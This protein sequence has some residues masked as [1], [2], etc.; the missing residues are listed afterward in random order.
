L[1]IALFLIGGDMPKRTCEYCGETFSFSKL[2]R[3]EDIHNIKLCRK[4][5]RVTKPA[6][7]GEEKS[8]CFTNFSEHKSAE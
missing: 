6:I 5:K 7:L 3:F 2:D 1:E 8:G 4:M